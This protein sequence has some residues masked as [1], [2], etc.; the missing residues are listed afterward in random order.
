[1]LN[2]TEEKLVRGLASRRKARA[3]EGLFV[4]EGIRV[5]EELLAAGVVLRLAL[6]SSDLEDTDRGEA[7]ARRL[8]QA[9]AVRA[10]DASALN[11]LSETRTNQGVLVVAETPAP[12]LS[13][14]E[15]AGS[16]T[17]L[18]L[19]GVQDPGNLGTLARTAAAFGCE[20][21]AC[22]PG[23]VDPWN[24]KA[25]RGSAGSLFRL[26]VVQPEPDEL[27]AWLAGHGFAVVGAD[28]AGE[29]VSLA[30]VAQ[31]TALVVGNEGAGIS[32]PVRERCER[33]V[34]VPMRGGTESLNVAVAGGILLYEI[35]REWG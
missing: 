4:A 2:R 23:T 13:A 7:L 27:W 33:L 10:V 15:P 34:A 8:E 25:V 19:D 20:L 16:A 32:G 18:V 3:V 11:R 31:R 24:P 17:A 5:V 30:G 14:L 29:A 1:M 21:L 26:A 35:T 22:L 12:A 9:G 6:V 28:A